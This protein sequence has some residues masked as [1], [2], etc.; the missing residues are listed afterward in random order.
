MRTAFIDTLCRIAA[1]DDRI[2][3]L[4]ADLGY[5]VLER[6][7]TRWPR[8]FVNVGVAEQNMMTVA[9]GLA[10]S[11]KIAF[12]YSLANFAAMRCLEQIRNDISYPHM[13][14]KIIAVGGGYAYGPQGDSHHGLEDLA[15][16]RS[17]PDMTVIAPADAVEARL[18]VEA[19]ARLDGPV[20]L[21]LGKA[22]E[23]RVHAHE[24]DFQIGR[25]ITLREGSDLTLIGTG[26]M[27]HVALGAAETLATRH[28]GARVLSMHTLKPIDAQTIQRAAVQTRAIIIVE[29]YRRTGGLGSATAEVLAAMRQPHAPLTM[30]GVDDAAKHQ[31]GS[32][33]YLRARMGDL[34]EVAE[35]ALQG[36]K[37]ADER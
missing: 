6:F 9:A 25:A 2:W 19:I 7:A 11:G 8:R 3:L 34:I 37:P 16:M 14:V 4:T 12:T 22:G 33:D 29:E 26:E 36:T 31:T 23:P 13:N 15:V 21:R 17:M 10:H 1:V 20:Y 32:Q 18:A 24:P 30:F 5:S 27:V 28:I 35:R